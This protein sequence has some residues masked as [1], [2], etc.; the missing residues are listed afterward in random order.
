MS[1]QHELANRRRKFQRHC[2]WCRWGSVQ[3]CDRALAYPHLNLDDR[4]RL[5]RLRARVV[6][7]RRMAVYGLVIG[8]VVAVAVAVSTA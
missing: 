7:W 5:L 3:S 4:N 2:R 1:P 8:A 6:H